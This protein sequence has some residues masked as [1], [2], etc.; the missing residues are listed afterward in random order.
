[1]RFGETR[2]AVCGT[3]LAAIAMVVVGFEA[4]LVVAAPAIFVSGIGFYMLHN[5][6]Q[7]NATQMMPTRRGAAVALFATSFFVGQ[8]V[9]VAALGIVVDRFG[10]QPAILF[11]AIML[12][13]IGLWLGRRLQL[14]HRV[15]AA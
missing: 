2:L 6:L 5:T 9:G 13:P 15:A 7:T 1:M 3:L 12:L 4:R 11:G 14:R 10:T 8:S